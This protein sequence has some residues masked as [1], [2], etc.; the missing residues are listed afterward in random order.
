MVKH[1]SLDV[2]GARTVIAQRLMRFVFNKH[3]L[4]WDRVVP[5]RGNEPVAWSAP[6][7]YVHDFNDMLAKA[8][9]ER[10]Y[11]DAWKLFIV[12]DSEGTSATIHTVRGDFTSSAVELMTAV[13]LVIAKAVKAEPRLREM[14]ST[15]G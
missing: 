11:K 6:D 1:A 14:R 3:S 12:T 9:P 5:G 13:T 2:L 10:E 15:D 8:L 7:I 4:G